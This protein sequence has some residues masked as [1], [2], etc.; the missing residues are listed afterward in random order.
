MYKLD[1]EEAEKREIKLPTSTGS[2]KKQ[3]NFKKKSTSTSLTMLKCLTVWITTNY[4]KF[5]KRWEYQATLPASYEVCM[6]VKKQQL[7]PVM[8]QQTS[9]KL[10]KEYV[11]AVYCHLAYLIYRQGT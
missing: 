6:Q 1:F 11:K 2:S 7:G 9:Y 10:E 4:G 3:E 8:E 5:L